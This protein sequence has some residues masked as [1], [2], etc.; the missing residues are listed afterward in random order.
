MP[1]ELAMSDEVSRR[2]FYRRAQEAATHIEQL[3]AERSQEWIDE[4]MRL[5]ED[6]AD[7]KTHGGGYHSSEIIDGVR[8]RAALLAHLTGATK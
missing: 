3:E 7:K 5:A 2:Q 1:Y 6:Y 8:A 4:A